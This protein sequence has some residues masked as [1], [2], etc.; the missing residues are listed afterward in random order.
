[1]PLARFWV[2][3][4]RPMLMAMLNCFGTDWDAASVTFTVKVEVLAEVAVG[5]PVMFP[6]ASSVK[7]AGNDPAEIAQL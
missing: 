3:M 7:P 6:A 2:V 1:M 5:V 4:P